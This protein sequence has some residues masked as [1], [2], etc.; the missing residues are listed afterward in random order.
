MKWFKHETDAKD[1]EKMKALK[2]E[3]GWSAV[4]RYWAVMEIVASK[5]DGSER[6]HYEQSESEWLSFLGLKR[7]KLKT[8]LECLKNVF[9][10]KVVCSEN[11]IKIEIPNL[12]KKRDDYSKKS[13]Q[14]S[15][16]VS[17]KSPL[18]VEEEKEVEGDKEKPIVLSE[19]ETWKIIKLE[20]FEKRWKSYPGTKAGKKASTKHWNASIKNYK[21]IELYDSAVAEYEQYVRNERNNGFKDLKF[22]HASTWFNNWRDFVPAQKPEFKLVQDQEQIKPPKPRTPGDPATELLWLSCRQKI[23]PQITPDC[24][25]TWFEPTW[26][27]SLHKDLLSVAVPNQFIRKCLI[28]NYRDLIELTLKGIAGKPILVEFIISK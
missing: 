22:K 11:I 6:C 17:T 10:I 23:R 8:F 24:F 19:N 28:E 21:D 27:Y 3:L 20:T 13:V 9:K 14:G 25:R 2:H 16:S 4:G 1:S 26:P 18:E 12:L 5:M 7:N 15:D